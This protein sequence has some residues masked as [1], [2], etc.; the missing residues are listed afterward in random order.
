MGYSIGCFLILSMAFYQAIALHTRQS[1]IYIICSVFIFGLHAAC[2]WNCLK[3]WRLV[4]LIF[5]FACILFWILARVCSSFTQMLVFKQ[6]FSILISRNGKIRCSFISIVIFNLLF[7]IARNFVVLCH[8]VSIWNCSSCMKDK[9]LLLSLMFSY[10]GS[11]KGNWYDGGLFEV[12]F[13][14]YNKN[15]TRY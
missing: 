10:V 3:I 2:C 15:S 7:R 11:T 8:H 9:F 13:V 6:V 12:F 1:F 14:L 4:Y 5:S